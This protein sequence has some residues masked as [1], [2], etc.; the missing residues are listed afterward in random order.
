V[1]RWFAELTNA[2]CAALPTAASPLW[3]PT[4]AWIDAW[5]ADPQ[6]FVWNRTADEILDAL[7]A[8]CTPN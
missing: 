7:A 1:D 8:Y 4:C 6:P 5:N 3:K 2:I